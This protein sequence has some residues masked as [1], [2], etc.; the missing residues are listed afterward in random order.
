MLL[1]SVSEVLCRLE[2]NDPSNPNVQ[3]TEFFKQAIC[4]CT[5]FRR[6]NSSSEAPVCEAMQMDGM[7]LPQ[8]ALKGLE[9][10]VFC[11]P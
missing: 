7:I 4:L 10:F 9:S 1:N 8:A 3:T 5:T 11:F 6:V 2:R